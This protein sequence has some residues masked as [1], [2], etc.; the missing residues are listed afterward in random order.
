M[1]SVYQGKFFPF[2]YRVVGFLIPLAVSVKFITKTIYDLS[3]TFYGFSLVISSILLFTEWTLEINHT[4]KIIRKNIRFLIFRIGWKQ[5]YQSIEKI[6]INHI[7]E[8][9]KAFI[10]LDTGDKYLL[11]CDLDKEALIKRLF[12]YNASLHTHIL[13]N[14]NLQN[15]NWLTAS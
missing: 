6:Y 9:Y 5:P 4:E 2:T 7:K 8:V 1:I 10:K 15:P 11:D 14:S 13:D 3:F 12:E